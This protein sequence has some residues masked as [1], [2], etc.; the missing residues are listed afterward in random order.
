M[1]IMTPEELFNELDEFGIA[2]QNP[3]LVIRNFK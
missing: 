2:H 3:E 1:D